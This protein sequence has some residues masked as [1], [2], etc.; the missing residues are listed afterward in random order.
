[1]MPP[2]C[3]LRHTPTRA[4]HGHG[5][6]TRA[7][8][9]PIR[10]EVRRLTTNPIQPVYKDWY[11]TQDVPWPWSCDWARWVHTSKWIRN[12]PLL[13]VE[14]EFNG[15]YRL[16]APLEP[17]LFCDPERDG[18]WHDFAF[19]CGGQYYYYDACS[20]MVRR[21]HG[22]YASPAA[23]LRAR[24]ET[25]GHLPPI[26]PSVREFVDRWYG[27]DRPW[28]PSATQDEDFRRAQQ[29]MD[30]ESR[31]PPPNDVYGIILAEDEKHEIMVLCG[32]RTR[33]N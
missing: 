18:E 15:P 20:P 33:I 7:L 14:Y 29:K 8:S 1:M 25:L 26:N 32:D 5:R 28:P 19:F 9:E 2:R 16:P 24:I 12:G 17:I 13:P 31:F 6:K 22:T 27:I 11:S 10:S 30:M 21:F 4:L 3:L 23:F